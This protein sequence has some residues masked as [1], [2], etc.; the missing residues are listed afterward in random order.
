MASRPPLRTTSVA[1]VFSSTDSSTSTGPPGGVPQSITALLNNPLPSSAASSYSWLSWP[2][3]TITLPDAAPPPPSHPC[4]ITRADFA[5]YLAAVS[6]PFAR[7]ADIRLHAHAELA[8]SSDAEGAPAASSGLAACLR[9]VPA[10][11]FKEDFALEDGPTFQAACPLDDDA[12]QERLGQHLDVVEAH[13][14]REIALRSESFYEAQGRL[15]GLDGE[16]VTA[17]GRIRELREVVQ[18]LTGDLVG[19]ARQVQE[20]NATR[21]NLVALQ[22]KLTVILYVSQ[23]LT[24]LKLL[25]A[26]ADCAGALD[27]IDNLQNLLDTDELAGLYCFRHIRDQL[28]TSLDSVNSILSAEFV[29]AAVPDGKA[30]DAMILSTVKRKASSPLNG[31]DHEGNIDEEESFILRDRLLPLI[32][33]LLRTDKFPA[34]LRIYRDTLI[35]VM[36][37][38]IKATVAE[39]LPVLTA[40][41]ID[42]DSVTGGRA[43]DADAGGQSLANKLRSLSSEGFVQ[44]LSAIFR[45][46]QVHLQQ[47]A[48][49]KR[50]VEWIMGNLDETLS[51]D[52]SNPTLQHGG[53]VIYDTQ[54]N[55]SSRGSNTLARSTSKIPFVQGKINDFSIISSIK[56]VRADVLRENTEAVFAACDAAHGR[57]AK[58]LGVRAGL[59]P[60]LRLEEFLIIYSI[61]EEFIAATEKIGGRLG[62][63]IRGILQQQSKQF[64]DYQHNVRMTKIKAVLDQETWVAVDV[65]EEFQAIVLSL[66]STYSSVNGM[67]MPSTD[68]NSKF[69]DHQPTSQ[70]LTYSAENNA[71]N[72][73]VTSGTGENQVESTSQSANNVAGNLKS[74]LQTIVHGGVGY[75]MVNCGLILLKMLSEYV[76]ISKC[77]PSLSLEVVQR[78]VEILKLFN[79]RTCQ[80]VLGAGAMQVSGLKSITS[81]HLALASQIISFIH[82]LIPDIRRVLFLKIPEARKQLLMSELDRVA[83]DY[84][85]HRD[86]IHSKLVQIMRER[87]LANLRKLPQIV[88]GWNA[89]QDNDVQPSQFAKAVTKEVT[90]LHRILSQTLLEVEVQTIFRQVVQIFHSHITE[91]FTKLEVSTPQAKDRLCRDVQHILACIRKLPAD[92]FSSET[93]PN[94]GLL[95]EFLAENFGTKVGE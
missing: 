92:N 86:E 81:K 24:A 49:V 14:V 10:L 70:E 73:K 12:L 72:G 3:T 43:T 28:G 76:D 26:A 54:E 7:F 2:P 36:K 55:D 61:T 31:T 90:Y 33:C 13:L 29:H 5:P 93:I 21:G 82:S 45:I 78:V 16:I 37:A 50:I 62:Y 91:A 65:P 60:R 71:D 22:Q 6:D 25:V 64:V 68:D 17:V 11:F 88:E 69:S 9:E 57:W 40:R 79:T 1:S 23:A 95:D 66:S 35:T 19:A 39:L 30:V 89:P 51:I 15:R 87:L 41:P 38:S 46:V 32:I 52:A 20:L 4:E 74:T 27:V 44:L 77:L 75:H 85:I 94:Y 83:Q 48:E 63:N 58:L 53:S 42:S 67:E 34:V 47:A 80:L 18:V 84:K 8:A 59:H 56:N